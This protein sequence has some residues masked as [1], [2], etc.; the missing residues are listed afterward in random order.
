MRERFAIERFVLVGD[1]GMI[2]QKQVDV[3]QTLEGI[4]WITALRPGAI[5]RLLDDQALQMDLFDERNLFE[6]SHPA[7]N[8]WWPVAIRNWPSAAP[9]NAAACSRPP[10]RSW[11]RCARWW[12][13]DA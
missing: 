5:R 2:T 10:S 3:L 4:D 7:G 11:I 6:L 13:A 8:G 9:R 1:R 12:N